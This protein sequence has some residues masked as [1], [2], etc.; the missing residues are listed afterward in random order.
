[1]SV[2][3]F[4]VASGRGLLTL[5]K[6]AADVEKETGVRIAVYGFDSG[7]GLPKPTGDHRD[8]PDLWLAGD[9]PMDEAALRSRLSK[10]TTLVIG[11]VAETVPRFL[12]EGSYPPVGFAAMDLDYY[13]STTFALQLFASPKRRMLRHAVLYFDDILG[14]PY[15]SF[16]GE[17]LAITEFNAANEAVKI[18]QWYGVEA[19]HP[20][21]EM[22]WLKQ[23]FIAHDLEAI[24][25]YTP[26]DRP[27]H[28][29]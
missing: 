3:E 14:L 27:A 24:S 26:P 25:R 19:G 18:D 23:L 11:D 2:I 17:R 13:S 12:D 22:Y 4:G 21:P 8:H 5:E 29:L 28:Q 9:Y 6:H 1:M 20:F 7:A 15:N 16:A 10:R